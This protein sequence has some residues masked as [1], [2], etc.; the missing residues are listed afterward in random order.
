MR[1]KWYQMLLFWYHLLLSR[2]RSGRGNSVWYQNSGICYHFDP[3]CDFS[4]GKWRHPAS[5]WERPRCYSELKSTLIE[6]T[7]AGGYNA[8]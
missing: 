6:I 2:P 8:S 3:I 5:K 4:A 7:N 1:S